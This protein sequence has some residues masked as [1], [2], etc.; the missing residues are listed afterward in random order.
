MNIRLLRYRIVAVGELKGQAE[1]ETVW[2][3][4]EAQGGGEQWSS[5]NP[6]TCEQNRANTI[7]KKI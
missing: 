4:A 7:E 2:G 6:V 5:C 3:S 1:G